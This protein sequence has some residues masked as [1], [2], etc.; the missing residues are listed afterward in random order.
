[1]SCLYGLTTATCNG[2]YPH[3]FVVLG[4][5]LG[6]IFDH[7]G[8]F[9]SSCTKSTWWFYMI[10]Q[11]QIRNSQSEISIKST[12]TSKLRWSPFEYFLRFIIWNIIY[13]YISLLKTVVL[14]IPVI[15]QLRD[16]D[17]GGDGGGVGVECRLLFEKHLRAEREWRGQNSQAARLLFNTR[18]VISRYFHLKV[19]P[20]VLDESTSQPS[21]SW[22]FTE[23][24]HPCNRGDAIK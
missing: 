22:E 9:L 24:C 1:M 16:N 21:R 19:S 14:Y 15:T 23:H 20:R 10:F 6:I 5:V 18:L 8:F 7:G 12:D 17:W 4:F 3:G 13:I 11:W 2:E